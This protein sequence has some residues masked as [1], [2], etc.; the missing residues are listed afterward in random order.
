MELAVGGELFGRVTA[1]G[2]F[3]ENEAAAAVRQVV[4]RIFLRAERQHLDM[5]DFFYHVR[6][7]LVKK[8]R[9]WSWTVLYVPY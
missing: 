8:G 2:K 7:L 6:L 5:L 3:S 9:D 4:S 1:R